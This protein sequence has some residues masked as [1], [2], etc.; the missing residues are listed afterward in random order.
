M[1]LI[2]LKS[3]NFFF[4]FQKR[5]GYAYNCSIIPL[6]ELGSLHH[7]FY[8]LNIRLPVDHKKNINSRLGH[9][10]DIWLFVSMIFYKLS[11]KY[12]LCENL[13]PF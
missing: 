7:D 13:F 6:F 8:L 9:I 4:N 12:K 11:F 5:D 10:A 1:L 2:Y 3:Y